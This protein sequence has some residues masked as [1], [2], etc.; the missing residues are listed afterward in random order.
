MKVVA[1]ASP[2]LLPTSGHSAGQKTM[3]TKRIASAQDVSMAET[4]KR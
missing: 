2:S 4:G 3:E 1:N